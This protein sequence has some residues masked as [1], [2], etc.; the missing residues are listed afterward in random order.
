MDDCR[1]NK[2]N[3][4]Q[5]ALGA[6]AR[7]DCARF[8]MPGHKGRGMAGFW[9]DEL[10][11][12][13]VTE[14]SGTDNLHAPDGPIRCAEREMAKAYG[15][16]ASFY[17]VNGSTN[18]VQA[19]I[20]ALSDTDKLLLSRDCHRSAALGAALRGVETAFIRPPFDAQSGLPGMITP[21]QL[22]HE[23][24]RTQAT[25]VL[26]TSP[27]VYGFCADVKQ[28]AEAAHRHGALLLVDGAHGAHF[29]FSDALPRGLGGFADLFAHSQHKTM[30]AL[31]QAASLHLGECRIGEERVRRALAMTETTSPSYL[32]MAS[33]NW[34]VY[35][36]GRRD[37]SAQA[38][39]IE[40][41]V[42]LI[43]QIQGLEVPK[44]PQGCG[45][46]QRDQTRL[47]IDVSGRGLTG[48]EAQEALEKAGV[49]IEMSD[50]RRL[51]LI[52]TPD[53][54]P[55]WYDRLLGALAALPQKEAL[56]RETTDE[57]VWNEPARQKRT[58]RQAAF[59]DCE[60]VPLESAAGRTA[61]EAVGVYPP[62]VALVLPGEAFSQR[63]VE[64]LL[65]RKRTGSALFG[66]HD[67]GV[68]TLK[69]RQE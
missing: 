49:Y 47:V 39:R 55:L 19:M 18:A 29:P 4:L 31:T 6:Y 61:A 50:T 25:A 42:P 62:G 26:I 36:A 56:R 35:M 12:W 20:F 59:A 22:E 1:E 11:K 48:C 44:T 37:W 43:E 15:A 58:L 7:A 67:G 5:E 46:A 34:S 32:L 17:V 10:I 64:Y 14:L 3:S 68:L 54:D 27:N 16:K 65:N 13:D 38:A 52:T 24:L 51:V 9:R 69:E 30:D 23:L 45:V 8:H 66:V 41:L 60:T 63:A 28:L 53:D 57:S 33:L 40:A 2:A 21:E